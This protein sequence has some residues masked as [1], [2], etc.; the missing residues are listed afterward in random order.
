MLMPFQID[1]SGSMLHVI[2]GGVSFGSTPPTQD[3]NVK[4]L[5]KDSWT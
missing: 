3:D 5:G 4:E 2:F 1:F